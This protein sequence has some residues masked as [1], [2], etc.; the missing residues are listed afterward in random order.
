MK[1]VD[2]HGIVLVALLVGAAQTHFSAV[3]ALSPC[4]GN[5][6]AFPQSLV[7]L[8]IAPNKGDVAKLLEESTGRADER[9][10]HHEDEKLSR[11]AI[12][13][14]VVSGS[15]VAFTANVGQQGRDD[16]LKAT[17]FAQLAANKQAI[18]KDI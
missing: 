16:I 9:G 17:L 8:G 2:S 10:A 15:V 12:S 14:Y 1:Q 7:D 3:Q 5:L 6:G 18:R 13:T 11:D 4:K